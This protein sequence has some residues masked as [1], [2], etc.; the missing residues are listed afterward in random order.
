MKIKPKLISVVIQGPLYR[1]NDKAFDGADKCVKS[2]RKYLPEAE[3]IISTWEDESLENLDFDFAIKNKDPGG[4]LKG[5]VTRQIISTYAGIQKSTRPYILKFRA[6]LTLKN[7]NI[8]S[9]CIVE[10]DFTNSKF[11]FRD[12][13][14]TTTNLIL[15]NPR[16]YH[17]L[18]HISDLVQF[19]RRND[20][21]DLWKIESNELSRNELIRQFLPNAD[22]K[23]LDGFVPEQIIALRW[24]K[25]NQT[26]FNLKDERT[27]S[28]S[29]IK[30]WEEILIVNFHIIDF[31]KSGINFEFKYKKDDSIY[32]AKEIRELRKRFIYDLYLPTTWLNILK[33]TIIFKVRKINSAWEIERKINFL[34]Y[35]S[36]RVFNFSMWSLIK[37]LRIFVPK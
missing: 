1:D 23:V 33:N 27:V 10:K 7:S 19:G 17:L 37:I 34:V 6:N 32:S 25:A 4:D 16:K 30:I 26:E 21:E 29:L 5:N 3:I 8:T 36:I 35:I 9:I 15:R 28:I 18:F 24:L 11:K 31:E 22:N 14:I 20:M 2:I 12:F 13:R